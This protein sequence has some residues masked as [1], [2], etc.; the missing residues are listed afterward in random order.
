[1]ETRHVFQIVPDKFPLGH[2]VATPGAVEKLEELG[3]Y[4]YEFLGRH[5]TGDWGDLDC[6]EKKQNELSLRQGLRLC[7]SYQLT[8]EEKLWI[9]TEANRS[10]TTILLPDEL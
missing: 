4:P 10:G 9:I 2:V 3:R 5:V 1:M 6:T 7:S 8:S